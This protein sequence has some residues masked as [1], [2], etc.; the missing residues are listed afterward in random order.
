MV[1]CL[2][3]LVAL[4]GCAP[5]QRTESPDAEYAARVETFVDEHFGPPP[6][7]GPYFPPASAQGAVVCEYG[8]WRQRE[9]AVGELEDRW[10][11][12][13]LAAA[14]EPS[15]Y[16]LSQAPHAPGRS[17]LRFTW[18]RSFH[19]PVVVRIESAGT[20]HRLIA[21][22]LSGSGGYEPGEVSRRITR[23]L[24]AEEARQLR[25]LL[26]R[27]L[28]FDLPASCDYGCDGAQWIFERVDESGYRVVNR[29]S[30]RHG[31]AAEIGA[32]LLGL[33]GWRFEDIY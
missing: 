21:K 16:R 3:L 15:L 33:T 4:A 11:S 18:L 9:S 31:P 32:H 10:F 24:S 2:W 19:A 27:N 20:S 29:W 13:H 30:P 1:R 22:E 8:D 12:R 17:I 7:S 26:S 23:A 5:A 6:S 14:R 25:I 28:F